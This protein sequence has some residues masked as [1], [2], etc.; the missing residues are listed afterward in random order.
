[1]GTDY[2]LHTHIILKGCSYLVSI[3]CKMIVC[4]HRRFVLKTEIKSRHFGR[5]RWM[6]SLLRGL[7]H[8]FSD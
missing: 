7:L 2:L 1:M 8:L 3:P 6:G 5:T 4:Q